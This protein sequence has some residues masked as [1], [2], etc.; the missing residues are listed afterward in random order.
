[1]EDE[2]RKEAILRHLNG[3][4]PKTICKDL[5]RSR[6]WFYKWLRRYRSGGSEWFKDRSKAPLKSP[7]ETPKQLRQFIISIRKSLE[8]EPFAQIGV[9]AIKWEL[10]KLGIEFPSDRTITRILKREGLVK[11]KFLQTQGS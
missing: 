7:N 1:M 4:S 11:K 10:C 2:L 6:H 8:S 3:E 9:S 5:N